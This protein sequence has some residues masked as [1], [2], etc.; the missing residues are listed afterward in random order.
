MDDRRMRRASGEKEMER[1]FSNSTKSE[2]LRA[3]ST[4]GSER[5]FLRGDWINLD[6][7]CDME[8]VYTARLMTSMRVILFF[9]SKS[10]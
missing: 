10:R 6:I 8:T 9:H 5:S 1:D 2:V 7:Q 4:L 3:V